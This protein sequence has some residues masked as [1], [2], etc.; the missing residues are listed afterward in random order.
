LSSASIARATR[1]PR[2][3]PLTIVLA[4]LALVAGLALSQPGTPKAAAATCD[5]GTNLALNHPATASSQENAS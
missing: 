1:G 5:T 4:V 3:R 2:S